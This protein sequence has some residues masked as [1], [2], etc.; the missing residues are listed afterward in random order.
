MIDVNRPERP[1]RHT[2]TSVLK[3]ALKRS[4]AGAQQHEASGQAHYAEIEHLIMNEFLEELQIRGE[5]N[6]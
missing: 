6:T 1:H 3:A 2:E 4:S 5:L